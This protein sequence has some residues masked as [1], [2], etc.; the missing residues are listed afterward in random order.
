MAFGLGGW[1]SA[2]PTTWEE[3]V[4]YARGIQTPH[5]VCRRFLRQTMRAS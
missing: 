2:L 1:D 5:K 3:A 4:A